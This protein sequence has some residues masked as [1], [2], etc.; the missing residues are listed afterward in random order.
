MVFLTSQAS[1]SNSIVQTPDFMD[2]LY[3]DMNNANQGLTFDN[4]PFRFR[5]GGAN[6]FSPM[7]RSWGEKLHINIRREKA[8]EFN[9]PFQDADFYLFKTQ[10]VA[11][12]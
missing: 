7:T 5:T 11:L 8:T 4:I 2:K 3:L 1:N 6:N 10:G 12:G 9:L